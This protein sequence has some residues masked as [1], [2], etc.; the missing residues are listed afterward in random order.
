[1]KKFNIY[2]L[3][4]L[5]SGFQL[6]VNAKN[7][8]SFVQIDEIMLHIPDSFTTS[9]QNIADYINAH[10]SSE[11]EKSRA[12]FYWIANNIQYDIDNMFAF[13]INQ[14]ET[15]EK[16]N[17]LQTHKGVCEDY[18]LLFKNIADKVGLKTFIVNGYTK[19][20]GKVDGNPHAWV[21][22]L[23][24]SKWYLTD[25]TWG[26][27]H[28][29][30]GIFIKQLDDGYFMVEPERFIKSHIPFDPIWQLSNHPITKQQ[31]YYKGK[32]R[33]DKSSFFNFADSITKMENQSRIERL[34]SMRDRIA[35]NGIVN[36]LDH[37]H[38]IHLHSKIV[39]YYQRKNEINYYAALSNYN[40]GTH[41]LNEYIGY[42][43]KSYQPLKSISEIKK[44]LYRA[45]DDFNSSLANLKKIDDLSDL[46]QLK[47]QLNQ[48]VEK[49]LIDLT[50]QKNELDKL[51][52]LASSSTGNITL[53]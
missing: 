8:K 50:V 3:L 11:K 6:T 7:S 24:D 22:L 36:Y 13:D 2:I 19:K 18:T 14:H 29:D 33:A 53:Q 31:F 25:P 9:P 20:S 17:I 35:S 21:A 43:N 16:E 41:L 47:N 52:N 38:L 23:I 37:D 4:L 12:I 40:E 5:F 39:Y 28:I 44:M 45:E 10:F 51:L 34:E 42:K 27:G 15:I 30:K 48:S 1:M 49:A 46:D 26:A 32:I